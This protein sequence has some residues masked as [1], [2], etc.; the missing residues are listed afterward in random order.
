MGTFGVMLR[1]FAASSGAIRASVRPA[2]IG[3]SPACRRNLSTEAESYQQL[4]GKNGFFG[5]AC[6]QP[7]ASYENTIHEQDEL[8]WD[9]GTAV[10]EPIFDS[11]HIPLSEA[12]PMFMAGFGLFAAVGLIHYGVLDPA[13]NRPTVPRAMPEAHIWEAYGKSP[14]GAGDDAEDEEDDE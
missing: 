5:T 11:D 2:S 13:A 12:I 4:T 10:R 8:W 1:R 3:R 6:E 7:L 9:D 14:A